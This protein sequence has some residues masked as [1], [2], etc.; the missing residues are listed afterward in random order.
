[1]NDVQPENPGSSELKTQI[2][3][4]IASAWARFAGARPGQTETTI[5]GNV[6]RCVMSD[7]AFEPPPDETE[8]AEEL[9]PRRGSEAGYRRDAIAA[10]ARATGYPVAALI[11]DHSSKDGVATAVFILDDRARRTRR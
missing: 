11:N 8:G 5:R 6:V 3:G 4:S 9:D 7:A 2:N 10:I 1:M